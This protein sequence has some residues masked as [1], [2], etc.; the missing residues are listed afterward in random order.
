[1]PERRMTGATFDFRLLGPFEVVADGREVTPARPKQRAALAFLV[2]NAN[3]VVSTAELAEAIWGESPP[4]TAQTALHGYVSALRKLLARDTIETRAPGYVLRLS[5]ERTDLG[6]FQSLV[7]TAGEEPDPGRREEILGAALGLFRGEPLADFRYD[8][9]AREHHLRIEE[10]RLAATEELLEAKLQLGRHT[11]LV[12]DLQR[13]VG[14]EPLRERMRAQL[15]LALY[16]CGRQ[17][18][19][20]AVYQQGRRMLADDLGIDPAP[21]L[22]RLERQILN[23]D[24]ALDLGPPETPPAGPPPGR[25]PAARGTHATNLPTQPSRMV[26]RATELRQLRERLTAEETRLITLTGAGGSGKTRLAVQ[27]A[28]GLL[29]TFASGTFFTALAPVDDPEHVLPAIARSLGIRETAGRSI[30]ETLEDYL[31]PRELLLVLDSFEHV[32][33]AAPGVGRLLEVAPGLKVLTTSREP[34]HIRGERTY[35]VAP[36]PPD[37]A[38]TLFVERA[39]AARP[40]FELTDANAGA[41]TEICRRMDGLPLAIELAAARVALLPPAALVARLGACLAIPTGRPRDAP[42]RH[43]TLR[44]TIDWSHDLLSQPRRALFAQLAVFAGGWTLEAA[45]AVCAA[46]TDV[47]DGVASLLDKGLIRSEGT[48]DEPRFGMLETIREYALER[49]AERHDAAIVRRRHAETMLEF[50][51]EARGFARGPRQSE[52]LCRTEVELDNIRSALAW[53]IDAGEGVLG[54]ELAEALEPFWYRQGHLREGLRWLE[55]LLE[56]APEA[57]PRLRAGALAAAGRLASELGFADQAKPRY[58]Q[59]LTLA[60]AAGD[61]TSEAWALHGLG[62]V[63]V[64]QGDR[65][66]GRTL[67]ERSFELFLDLG[68][69]AP[70]G[71]RLS[72]LCY[73]ARLDGDVRAARSYAERSVEQYR[74]A[75]DVAGVL[76]SQVDLGDLALIE[77]DSNGAAGWYRTV[78]QASPDDSELMYVLGGLAAVAA[79]TGRAQAAARLWGAAERIESGHDRGIDPHYRAQYQSLLGDIDPG[80]VAAGRA[81]SRDEVV[82][83]AREIAET[84]SVDG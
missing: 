41:V 37:D 58:E 23:Q 65:K 39:Q 19:A 60:R 12:P 48:D 42:E 13:L 29:S 50:A 59:S 35:P 32:L 56:L 75:G 61:R 11:E 78:L 34:L 84:A 5:P 44:A 62:Y 4:K 49:L 43:R 6:R 83:L 64:L 51:L 67:L 63:A 30:A 71:G 14:V 15:M 40:D 8:A 27:A 26:G 1:M 57:S 52:W 28:A 68:Q 45:E 46:D 2:L 20:L 10:M 80:A 76:G 24:A 55:P 66:H 74:Q 53:S 73:L 7:A 72:Y 9:F 18:A 21:E 70:A 17:S 38:V 69:H 79:G 22:Q 25:P 31:A 82:A 36:L 81:A 16:R 77:R 47:I 54:L 33:E 3:R